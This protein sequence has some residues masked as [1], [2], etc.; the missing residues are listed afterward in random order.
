M[1]GAESQGACRDRACVAGSWTGGLAPLEPSA[2]FLLLHIP[3]NTQNSSLPIPLACVVGNKTFTR[4]RGKTLMSNQSKRGE[5]AAANPSKFTTVCAWLFSWWTKYPHSQGVPCPEMTK[6][7]WW[8]QSL[9]PTAPSTGT[10]KGKSPLLYLEKC[11]ICKGPS[12][13]IIGNRQELWGFFPPGPGNS[14]GQGV[15]RWHKDT[16][17]AEQSS[18]MSPGYFKINHLLLWSQ[19]IFQRDSCCGLVGPSWRA[20]LVHREV[21]VSPGQQLPLSQPHHC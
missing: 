1:A 17:Q 10:Q 3:G 7:T 14:W 2:C 5:R 4:S 20:E 13:P 15:E 16:A 8:E 12:S 9:M 11:V 19:R 6:G 18:W 21:T